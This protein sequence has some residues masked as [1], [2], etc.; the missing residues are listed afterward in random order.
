[1]EWEQLSGEGES[2]KAYAAFSRFRD[3]GAS[4]SVDGA[5]RDAGNK[6]RAPGCWSKWSQLHRWRDRALAY[7]AFTDASQR[8]TREAK[9]ASLAARRADYELRHQERLEDLAERADKLLAK[10][11]KKLFAA[12]QPKA[13]DL[14]KYAKA[15][16]TL[17][18]IS[19]EALLG[20]RPATPATPEAPEAPAERQTLDLERLRN[21]SDEDLARLL[22]AARE[23]S[24]LVG[25]G[26]PAPQAE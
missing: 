15:A 20:P 19:R 17:V 9:L 24:E 13:L 2:A 16:L 12:K 14:A 3:L 5:W 25:G 21:A 7:D 26:T 8:E 11:E 1:M 23:L 22:G 18:A 6:G 4:R 10:A